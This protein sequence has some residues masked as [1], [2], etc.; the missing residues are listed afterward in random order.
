MKT[1]LKTAKSSLNFL[2]N[3]NTQY[4]TEERHIELIEEL[5]NLKNDGRRKVAERLKKAKEF[6]DLSE[7]SEYQEAREEQS[8]LERKI[9]EIEELLRKSVIIK[10]N[11]TSSSL[12]RIGAKVKIKKDGTEIDYTIVGSNEAHPLQGLISNESPIGRALIGK[13]AGDK[14]L[15]EA[16]KGKVAYEILSVE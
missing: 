10:K 7:N 14:I 4:L 13:K 6:G 5:K 16:P 12:I 9:Q 2:N 3:M 11:K 15:V 1:D 8:M